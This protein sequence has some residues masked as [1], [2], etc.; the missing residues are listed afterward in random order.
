MIKKHAKSFP[1]RWM[2]KMLFVS[3]SGYYDWRERP[4]SKRAQE[5]ATLAAKIKKIFDDESSR[6]GAKRIA[7][8]Q[9]QEGTS[10]SRHRVARIMRL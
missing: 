2:C 3:P 8:R 4:P 6:V 10:V 7:K 1:V 5:N 9:K